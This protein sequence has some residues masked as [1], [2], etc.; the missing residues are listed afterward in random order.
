MTFLSTW[1]K[2]KGK[3]SWK[4][5]LEPLAWLKVNLSRFTGGSNSPSWTLSSCG[6]FSKFL[7]HLAFNFNL[8]FVIFFSNCDYFYRS[9]TYDLYLLIFPSCPT[10]NWGSS[11]GFNSNIYVKYACFSPS[12]LLSPASS[13][14][15]YLSLDFKNGVINGL[16]ATVHYP[17]SF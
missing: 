14:D 17:H 13:H 1:M 3:K 5:T 7:W 11:I 15:Y 16:P 8:S 12:S 2:R 10:S 4:V 6:I 9:K